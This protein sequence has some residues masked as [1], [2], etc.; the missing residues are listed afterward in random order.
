MTFFSLY[1]PYMRMKTFFSA[2][3]GLEKGNST[4]LEELLQ[5]QLPAINCHCGAKPALPSGG[6][7]STPAIMCADAGPKEDDLDAFNQHFEKLARI[8]HFAD[9]W[10]A[11]RMA[12][13]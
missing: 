5:N 2:L 9:L 6:F 10:S 12:C 4:L 8:S 1:Q 7:E 3:H 11:H 13:V